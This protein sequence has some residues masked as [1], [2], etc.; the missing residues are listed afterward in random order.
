MRPRRHWR[1]LKEADVRDPNK[2][3]AQWLK[4]WLTEAPEMLNGIPLVSLLCWEG[5][6]ENPANVWVY[7]KFYNPCRRESPLSFEWYV[8]GSVAGC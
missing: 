5:T 8:G 2:T 4:E 7:V 3:V 6:V 1:A